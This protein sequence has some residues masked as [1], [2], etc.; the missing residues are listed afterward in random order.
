MIPDL[1]DND[2]PLYEQIYLFYRN[3]IIRNQLKDGEKLPSHR[4]LAKELGIGNNTV[5]RAYEQLAHEGYVQNHDR[6]GLFVS[7]LEHRDWPSAEQK[8]T[9]EKKISKRKVKADFS[10]SD[11]LV[12]EQNFPVKQWRKCSNWALDSISFQYQ[13]HEREDHLKEELLKYLRHHRGV[14]ATADRLVIGSGANALVFWLAFI[15]RKTHKKIVFEEP[16]YPRPR[17]MFSEFGYDVQPVPVK[18]NGIDVDRLQKEKADLVYLT[19]SH[20]YPTGAAMPVGNRIE[21]LSWARRHHAYIIE[22]DFD[23]E[24]RYKTKLMPSLQGLD[25]FNRVIYVGSFSNSLMPSL[26]VG[27]MILPEGFS[28]QYQSFSHLA[29]TVPSMIR[30]TLA[31]FMEK[32]FWEQ[33]LRRMRKIYHEKYVVCIDALN[34][35]PSKHI[36]F[37]NTPSGLNILLSVHTRLSEQSLIDRAL[38]QGISITATTEF[39]YGK[40]NRPE[41]PEVLLEFGNL[42]VNEIR[43]VITKLHKAWF[44]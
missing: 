4:S 29:N 34:S 14:H 9:N 21:I 13:E 36:H 33:H 16:C 23:C 41:Y 17:F 12:D 27:Y 24:F 15:L 40:R 3:A 38:K 10:P 26:R 11:Q 35:L 28:V 37:N 25:Q 8:L 30:K 31:F 22:D 5:I 6:K 44:S 18:K 19:P 20:Q 39:Y 7:R 32:G 43:K 1:H 42:P 2:Q